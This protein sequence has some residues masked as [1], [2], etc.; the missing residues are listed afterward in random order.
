MK[1]GITGVSSTGKT[2]L[3]QEVAK[4]TGLPLIGDKDVHERCWALM[5]QRGQTPSTRFFPKMSPED[6][7]N[8]SG[9]FIRFAA[10]WKT[11]FRSSL[12]MRLLLTSSI[13]SCTSARRFPTLFHKKK[14]SR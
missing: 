1:I 4:K 10:I 6:H 5:D 9:S 3:A 13:I 7:I 8:L 12:R 2:S 14:L 11:A